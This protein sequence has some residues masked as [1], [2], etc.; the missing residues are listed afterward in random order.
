[1]VGSRSV[2]TQWVVEAVGLR[3]L[4]GSLV[5][6][7]GVSLQLREGEILGLL[8]PNGAG[9]TTLVRSLVGRVKP[10]AG[11][12]KLFGVEAGEREQQRLGW[13]PQELAIYPKLTARD[14]LSAFGRYQGLQ[15]AALE[16]AIAR[17]L[18]WASLQ[19]RAGDIA[20][21]FSGGMKRRL[22]LAAGVIHQPRVVLMDEPTVGVD[23]QSRDH[24]F[25][26][27]EALRTEGVSI[28]YTTH[29]LEEAERF[30]DRIAVIDHGKVIAEGTKDELVRR[31]LGAM[32]RITITC[33]E[34]VPAQIAERLGASAS[35]SGNLLQVT[36]V[37]P[38]HDVGNLLT[39][40]RDAGVGVRDL[41][42]KAPSLE[43]V[44]LHLTGRGLRE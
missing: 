43:D 37:D 17:G 35:V 3:K 25:T 20:G 16:A 7:D 22:N 8:G 27:I 42:L 36:A 44:F 33:G 12:L 41:A 24:I 21:T 34:D 6:L 5:A 39:M 23:P 9:K 18:Q 10:D 11:E 4:Y 19:D 38:A 29:Y 2:S 1:M 31:Y 14:N 30:C 15:G 28:I 26:M 32:T 40:L 13:V